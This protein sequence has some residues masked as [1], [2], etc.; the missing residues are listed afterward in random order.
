M[1]KFNDFPFALQVLVLPII[2]IVAIIKALI[3]VPML[4]ISECN[5]ILDR[6]EESP[7][8]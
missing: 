8:K 6:E 4:I 3:T 5:K 2:W 1:N 7:T